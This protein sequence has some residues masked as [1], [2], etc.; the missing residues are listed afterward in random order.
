MLVTL[1]MIQPWGWITWKAFETSQFFEGGIFHPLVRTLPK[2]VSNTFFRYQN[3]SG[4][5]HKEPPQ[6]DMGQRSAT[7]L[8]VAGITHGTGDAFL[9]S[10]IPPQCLW[11]HQ[12]S[13]SRVRQCEGWTR[14][15]Q[16]VVLVWREDFC[17]PPQDQ[18]LLCLLH[19]SRVSTPCQPPGSNTSQKWAV[20]QC[21]MMLDPH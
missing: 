19:T 4:I 2:K 7:D 1:C 17:S 16:N 5:Y 13:P 14:S 20:G 18:G 9:V 3:T 12:E 15:P 21:W 10:W 11:K 8:A 6:A